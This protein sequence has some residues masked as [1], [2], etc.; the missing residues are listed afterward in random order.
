MMKATAAAIA[1][2]CGE[3]A[4]LRAALAEERAARLRQNRKQGD[5]VRDTTEHGV[6]TLRLIY[7]AMIELLQRTATVGAVV[8]APAQDELDYYSPEQFSE[9]VERRP[10]TVREW[11]RLG[12]IHCTK[13]PVSDKWEIPKSELDRYTRHKLL[14]AKK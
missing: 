12:R 11:C 14:S 5:V 8:A 6:E 1:D 10:Y 9:K 13:N 7:S 3:I 4:D 2:L